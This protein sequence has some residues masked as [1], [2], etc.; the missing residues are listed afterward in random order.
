M[1]EKCAQRSE[2]GELMRIARIARPDVLY[3]ATVYAQTS[4]TIN[5]AIINPID[6]GEI[7]DVDWDKATANFKT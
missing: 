2:L 5:E 6:F 3:D 7:D 4:E 1:E